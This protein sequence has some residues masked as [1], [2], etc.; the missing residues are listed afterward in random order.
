[1]T[2]ATA[3]RPELDSRCHT[4]RDQQATFRVKFPDGTRRYFCESHIEELLRFGADPEG[5]PEM[6]LCVVCPE[7]DQLTLRDDS[8]I[9]KACA[10]CRGDY[11]AIEEEELV[12]LAETVQ[13]L[14]PEGGVDTDE[15]AS[16]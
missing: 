11:D 5:L 10:D 6:P 2:F 3:D 1:M 8:A 4:H 15:T 14:D 13:H 12:E 7:C 9:N 16:K